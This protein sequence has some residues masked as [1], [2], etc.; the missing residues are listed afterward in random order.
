[1]KRIAVV[2][3]GKVGSTV[4]ELLARSG[5]YRVTVI[6]RRAEQLDALSGDVGLERKVLDVGRPAELAPA[7]RGCFAVVNAAPFH[8]TRSIAHAAFEAGIHYLDLTEDV[9]STKEV[10]QLAESGSSACIPSA[11]WLLVSS[12]SLQAISSKDSTDS[13][14]Y[15]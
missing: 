1:V 11:G 10:K 4:G 7:L 14:I 15:A 5:D 3:G 6:D 2:G 12:R 8:L 9:A 13:V